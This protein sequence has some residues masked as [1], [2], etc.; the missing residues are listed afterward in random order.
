MISNLSAV[1]V[2]GGTLCLSK[3]GLGIHSS[4]AQFVIAAP[5]GAG[6]DFC[7]KGLAYHKADATA[8]TF[9]AGH[10]VQAASTTCLYLV[11]LD[12]SGNVSTVQGEQVLTA[13]L[14][15]GT[16]VLQWPD[17]TSDSYCPIGAIKIACA[18]GYTFTH[19][20]TELSA[21]GITETYYD[22][23]AIPA[24]PLNS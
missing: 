2:R 17:P 6:I 18:V 11:Q 15:A 12:S 16:K 5:N 3:A 21:T 7:I 9:T 1:P 10:T 13:D 24:D 20:T 4:A 14:S 8:L 19:N 22:F 23:F